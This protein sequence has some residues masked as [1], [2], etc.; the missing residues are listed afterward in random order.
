MVD[1]L[2]KSDLVDCML[3]FIGIEINSLKDEETTFNMKVDLVYHG[4]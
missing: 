4:I 3:D 2:K 1:C